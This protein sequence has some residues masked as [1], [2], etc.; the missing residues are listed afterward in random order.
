M[1]DAKRENSNQASPTSQ[2]RQRSLKP[3]DCPG[4]GSDYVRDS[5]LIVVVRAFRWKKKLSIRLPSF[6]GTH[7]SINW[8][9]FE[10]KSCDTGLFQ[11]PCLLLLCAPSRIA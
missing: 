9:N 4:V 7:F 6:V 10:V 5:N 3:D 1:N 2:G 8:T 11:L